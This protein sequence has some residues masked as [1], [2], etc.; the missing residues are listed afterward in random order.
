MDFPPFSYAQVSDNVLA[1]TNSRREL[2]AAP[3]SSKMSSAD[4]GPSGPMREC[5]VSWSSTSSNHSSFLSH[6]LCLLALLPSLL[7]NETFNGRL[8]PPAIQL[9]YKA[10]ANFSID[11]PAGIDYVALPEKRIRL[12]P[13]GPCPRHLCL[14]ALASVILLNGAWSTWPKP[15]FIISRKLK[16]LGLSS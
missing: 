3:A 9:W 14:Q 5:G 16:H 2:S 15:T 11:F 7:L 1:F 12:L 4:R 6:N 13:W 10:E 8:R